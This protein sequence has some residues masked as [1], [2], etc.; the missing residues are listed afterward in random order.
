VADT[1]VKLAKSANP[2]LRFVSQDLHAYLK[3]HNMIRRTESV[4][5][6]AREIN[7]K[8]TLALFMK[9]RMDACDYEASSRLPEASYFAPHFGQALAKRLSGV[10][11]GISYIAKIEDLAVV[12]TWHDLNDAIDSVRGKQWRKNH[13]SEIGAIRG[14]R[15]SKN[16]P[17][18]IL[19]LGAARLVFNPPVQKDNLQKGKGWLSKRTFTFDELFEAWGC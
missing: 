6:Y 15:W 16:H 1:L 13:R 5:V 7:E 14:W 2:R 4:D 18:S 19:F 10:H 9:A 8:T 11:A 12:R 17:R 3:E